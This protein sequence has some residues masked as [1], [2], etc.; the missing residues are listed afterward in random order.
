MS[1]VIWTPQPKQ[2]FMLSRAEDEALY[3]GAAGGGKTDYL[4]IEGARQVDIPYY[5]GLILRKTTPELE[6]IIERA[7]A[8]YKS[9]YPS[10]DFNSTKHTFTFPSGAKIRF[11]SLF[12]PQDK[13][14]Y[15]GQQYDFIGFDELTH[16]LNSEYDYL[17]SRNRGNGPDTKVYMRST[18]NPGGIGH[19]WVKSRFVTAGTPGQTIWEKYKVKQPD[20]K[21]IKFWQSRIFVP[22]SVFDNQILLKNDPEYLMRLAALPE[23]ERNALLYGNWDSFEGQVFTEFVDDPA[24]YKDRRGTHVIEPFKIP[25]GWKIIRSFDWGFTKPFSVGWNAVDND[26][27]YYRI[28]EY[29]GCK[30][31]QP[32]V[33][34]CKTFDEVA[35]DIRQIEEN[36]INLKGRKIIG[37]ADPAIFADNGSGSSIEYSMRKTAGIAFDRGD[38]SR[39][40]GKMQFHYRLAFDDNS[41]P[42]FYCFNTNRDFIRT[43]PNLVYSEK[44]VED[45]DTD[46]EDHIYDDQRYA[47]MTNLLNP[48]KNVLDRP[49]QY[50]PLDINYDI[51]KL[52]R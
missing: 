41:I 36:D 51:L 15:Q 11:G 38:N 22:S 18:A 14:K 48:R 47:F 40:A 31:N 50:D 4:V 1:K 43:I 52:T 3:G 30:P 44:N 27:R 16:F 26:G 37:V 33:G 45:I 39:I 35:R 29:Y 23:A 32:N 25:W 17:K 46:G 28:K 2:E 19:G 9:V 42:M 8:Y 49:K 10:V 13:H 20:G 24:H 5:R 21:I 7:E 6:Q 34:V 12:R